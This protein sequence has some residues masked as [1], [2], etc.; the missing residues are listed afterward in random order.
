MAGIGDYDEKEEGERG[1]KMDG[2]EFYGH[3]NQSPLRVYQ[4]LAMAAVGSMLEHGQKKSELKSKAAETK[5][6]STE[7]NIQ[8]S[9]P[10]TASKQQLSTFTGE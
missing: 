5:A 4:Q 7:F 2:T 8:S 3:G 6:R 10:N 1:Y 9:G